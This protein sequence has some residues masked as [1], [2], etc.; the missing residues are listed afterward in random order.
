MGV[1]DWLGKALKSSKK[2]SSAVSPERLAELADAAKRANPPDSLAATR[3][4]ISENAE[5]GGV[6]TS[7]PETVPVTFRQAVSRWYGNTPGGFD[8]AVASSQKALREHG[9]VYPHSNSPAYGRW[10]PEDVDSPTPARVN[11]NLGPFDARGSYSGSR[12]DITINPVFLEA[13][14][15]AINPTIE[16]EVTHALMDKGRPDGPLGMEEWNNASQRFDNTPYGSASLAM[17]P[18]LAA[19]YNGGGPGASFAEE[20]LRPLVEQEKYAMK[21]AELDPRIAEVRRRYA[22]YAGK[23]VLTPKDA[24][25]AWDWWRSN[26]GWLEDFTQPTD[27]PSMTYSQFNTYD[28]LPPESKQIMFKRMTQVPALLAPVAAGAAAGQ[29]G[30]LDGLRENR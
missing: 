6:A 10:N 3:T 20:S 28:S 27:T 2:A 18:R 24:S 4:M 16:H 23:D 12:R 11:W 5:P 29:Q 30:L 17:Q 15:Q 25:D 26:R 8:E 21:R 19:Q 7:N 9:D 14:P 13:R 1:G 22:F